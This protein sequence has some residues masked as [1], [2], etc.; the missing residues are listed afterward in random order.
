MDP[1]LSLGSRL[2]KRHAAYVLAAGVFVGLLL[3]DLASRLRPLLPVA[4]A[5]PMFLALLRIEWQDLMGHVSRPLVNTALCLWLLVV[6]PLLVWLVVGVLGVEAGLAT[7]LVLMA[8][9]PPIMSSPAM[10]LLLRLDA[11][12]VLVTMV[13]ASLVAPFTLL[14]VSSTMVGLELGIQ[15][16]M[17]FLRLVLLIGGCL[18]LALL[19]R[20]LMGPARLARCAEPLDAVALLSVLVFAIAV[21][22]GVAA[23][24]AASPGHVLGF[25]AVAFLANLLLQASGAMLALPLGRRAALTI[26]FASGNRNMGLLLAVLPVDSEPDTLLFFAVAQFP[27]YMLP[28]ALTPVYR[29]WR[30]TPVGD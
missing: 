9:C 22:D 6:A 21:M 17:L 2:L 4:V 28:A 25:V 14:A 7:A 30:E 29:R 8:A 1:M 13:I 15:P 23:L 26:G 12:L 11:P 5:I 19:V 18:A 24:A 10:A 20:R 3:P 16:L 27:I